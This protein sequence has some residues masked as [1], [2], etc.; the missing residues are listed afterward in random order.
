MEKQ[1]EQFI[2]RVIELAQKNV[3]SGK[4]GPFAAIVI[5]DNKIISY[6]YNQ[7]TSK[8]DPTLHAEIDCPVVKSFLLV[9]RV[10]C[11]F[12]QYIGQI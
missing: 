12:R 11:V 2:E 9:I 8:K 6:G 1:K 7:V 4:G 5:K 3:L 10:L